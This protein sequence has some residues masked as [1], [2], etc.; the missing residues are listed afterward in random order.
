MN[1]NYSKQRKTTLKWKNNGELS[2]DE[3]LLNGAPIESTTSS[4][5]VISDSRL[6]GSS[7]CLSGSDSSRL[8]VTDT[9]FESCIQQGIVAFGSEVE[10]V[11][12]SL[13][14]GNGHGI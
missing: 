5:V 3:T 8:V 9:V 13:E 6:L 11:G 12:I 2:L 4:T 10:F 7:T 14:D 1:Q